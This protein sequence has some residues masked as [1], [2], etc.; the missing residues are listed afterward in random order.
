MKDFFKGFI[1]GVRE[2]PRGY[3]APA[4]VLFHG[5]KWFFGE[6]DHLVS[7]QTRLKGL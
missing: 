7:K 4:L 2:T 6:V 5:A 1:R 3:F